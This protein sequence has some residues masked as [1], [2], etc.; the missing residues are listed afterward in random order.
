MQNDTN[1][2][3]N[4]N[5]C[6]ENTLISLTYIGKNKGKNDGIELIRTLEKW[7]ISNKKT[8][9]TSAL[10]INDN[11]FIQNIEGSRLVIN[12][13]LAQL[14]AEY[15]G[16]ALNVVEVKEIKGRRWDGFLIEY[17]APSSHGIALTL[18]SFLAGEDFNPYLMKQ[19]QIISLIKAIF[20]EK[21]PQVEAVV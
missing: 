18:K 8:D 9:V 15:P 10:A 1:Y 2:S 13:V 21:E 20:E 12:E 16:V 17:L 7:R 11:Y 19:T 6:G 5:E 4:G 14:L 3:P